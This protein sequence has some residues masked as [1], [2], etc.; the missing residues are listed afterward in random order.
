MKILVIEDEEALSRVLE[1]KLKKSGFEVKLANDGEAG[2]SLAKSFHPELILLDL[3]LPKKDGFEVLK[4][5]KS[6]SDLKNI[7]VI[8]LSNLGEDENLKKCLNLGASDYFVK[9]QH[10]INEVIKK[11]KDLIVKGS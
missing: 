9:T 3:I 4:E 7:N 5:L 10:P 1:E 11:I 2:M 8:V 6:N